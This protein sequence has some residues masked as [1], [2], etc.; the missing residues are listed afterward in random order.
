MFKVLVLKKFHGLS[1][2]A[3]EE[4]IFDRTKFNEPRYESSP[5]ITSS[6]SKKPE[7]ICMNEDSENTRT[8]A[9]PTIAAFLP[10]EDP[11]DP[12]N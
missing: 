10:L 1:D 2:D 3:T 5:G 8:H 9:S 12:L 6:S 11:H 4:Q 7:S